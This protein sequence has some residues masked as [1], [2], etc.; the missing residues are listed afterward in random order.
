[1]S[2]EL[3]QELDALRELVRRERERAQELFG[4]VE[5]FGQH[6]PGCEWDG[7]QAACTCGFAEAWQECCEAMAET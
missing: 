4:I 1:M 3:P 5:E 2:T 6:L 7:D